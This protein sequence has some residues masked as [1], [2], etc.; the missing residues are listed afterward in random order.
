MITVVFFH[1]RKNFEWRILE[2]DYILSVNDL[3]R[4]NKN[5]VSIFCLASQMFPLARRKLWVIY[6]YLWWISVCVWITD[7]NKDEINFLIFFIFL[8]SGNSRTKYIFYLLIGYIAS[9]L[10]ICWALV[11]PKKN[12][13]W[14]GK[15]K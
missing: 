9:I 7:E 3:T 2:G 14:C 4:C 6:A 10:A 12:F 5:V 1:S 8:S 13:F 11:T 15:E